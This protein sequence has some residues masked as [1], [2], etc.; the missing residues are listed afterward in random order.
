MSH[1]SPW[2]GDDQDRLTGAVGRATQIL[3]WSGGEEQG[4]EFVAK[5][6]QGIANRQG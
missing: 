6:G 2:S 5:V 1:E 3:A 4:S